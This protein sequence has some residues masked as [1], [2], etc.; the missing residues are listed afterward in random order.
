[1]DDAGGVERESGKQRD[2]L[3]RDGNSG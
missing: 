3:G 2:A 1:L